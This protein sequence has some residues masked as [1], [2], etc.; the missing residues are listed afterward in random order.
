MGYSGQDIGLLEGCVTGIWGKCVRWFGFLFGE[1][2]QENEHL[3]SLLDWD[4]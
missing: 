3:F 1:G 4:C 2:S